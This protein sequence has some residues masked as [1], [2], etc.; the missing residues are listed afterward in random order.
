MKLAL[1]TVAA[2]MSPDV[3]QTVGFGLKDLISSCIFNGD[4]CDMETYVKV[5]GIRPPPPS[6]RVTICYVIRYVTL[7]VTLLM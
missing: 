3:R 6:V 1:L 7:F 4:P 2:K 5:T